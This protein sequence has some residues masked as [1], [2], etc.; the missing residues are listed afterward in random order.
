[1]A[2]SYKWGTSNSI[3]KNSQSATVENPIAAE[4]KEVLLPFVVRRELKEV[5][6]EPGRRSLT[7][8]YFEHLL[9][10]DL[11][12]A[13][14]SLQTTF[15]D[16]IVHKHKR[17][18]W[19]VMIV[20][21]Q[22]P[23]DRMNPWASFMAMTATRLPFYDIQELG[24]RCYENWENKNACEFLAGC[25]FAENWLQEYANEVYD[26]VMKE[27]RQDV[28]YEKDFPWEMAWGRSN[29]TRNLG[30]HSS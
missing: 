6:F 26:F 27:G 19:N 12:L 3:A 22:L 8:Q 28:L 1:M 23:Y 2:V 9:Q 29:N 18:L 13:Q 11:F 17:V 5:D 21:S 16:A 14:K 10:Q 15:Y 24:V 20:L 25:H 30:G 4:K 7:Q